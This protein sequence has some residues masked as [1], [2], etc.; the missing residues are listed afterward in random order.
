MLV[1][2][3]LELTNITISGV[4]HKVLPLKKYQ[5]TVTTL[6]SGKLRPSYFGVAQLPKGARLPLVFQIIP[7]MHLV[8]NPTPTDSWVHSTRWGV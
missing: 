4:E 8:C 1:A 7:A 6:V 3:P 2:V 5:R